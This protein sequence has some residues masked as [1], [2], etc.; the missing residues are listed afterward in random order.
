MNIEEIDKWL[1]NE[2][3]VS[4]TELEKLHDFVVDRDR[5][6]QEQK[7]K[8]VND[9]LKRISNLE[10]EVEDK[11]R[12]IERLNNII[13]EIENYFNKTKDTSTLEERI[14]ANYMLRYIKKLKGSDKE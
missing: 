14:I 4:Y 7:D 9:L 2:Y 13:N 12:E 10:F 8:V 5:E 6:H 1:D 11:Q 3:G